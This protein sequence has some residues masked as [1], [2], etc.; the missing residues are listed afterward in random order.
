[1]IG[2]HNIGTWPR[3]GT[4]FCIEE[5]IQIAFYGGSEEAAAGVAFKDSV[6]AFAVIRNRTKIVAYVSD[7]TGQWTAIEPEAFPQT[8]QADTI[9]KME[10]CLGKIASM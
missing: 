1:M 5:N 2:E 9:R 7:T 4:L 10:S 3:I 8:P 6:A